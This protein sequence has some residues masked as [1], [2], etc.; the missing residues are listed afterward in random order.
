M[1]IGCEFIWPNLIKRNGKII[2]ENPEISRTCVSRASLCQRNQNERI[3]GIS[4]CTQSV[5]LLCSHLTAFVRMMTLLP[6]QLNVFSKQ[7]MTQ[8]DMKCFVQVLFIDG[9]VDEGA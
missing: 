3:N 5:Y 8:I 7:L 2:A 4:N 9:N 6:I 1:V